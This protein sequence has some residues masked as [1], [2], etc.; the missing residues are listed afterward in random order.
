MRLGRPARGRA[1]RDRSQCSGRGS[2]PAGKGGLWHPAA[3]AVTGSP[4]EP[5]ALGRAVVALAG[6]L[7]LLAAGLWLLQRHGQRS[8]RRPKP[9]T[10]IAVT[11]AIALDARVRLLLVRRDAV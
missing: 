10:R 9:G 8:L 11:S 1:R 5:A 7:M 3:M 2:A 6:V 4:V